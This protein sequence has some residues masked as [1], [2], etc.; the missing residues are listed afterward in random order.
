MTKFRALALAVLAGVAAAGAG[1]DTLQMGGSEFASQF[2]QPGKPKR[3][4]TQANVEAQFGAP[5]SRRAPVG[6][7]PISRWEYANFVV[8]FEHDRVIHAVSKR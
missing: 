7:P 3:G 4:M 5:Q 8:F 1:A 6:D 2:E